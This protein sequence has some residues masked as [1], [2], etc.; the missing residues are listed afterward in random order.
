MAT[1]FTPLRY[2]G[3]KTVYADLLLEFIRLNGLKDVVLVE[4]YAGGAGASIKLLLQ[5]KVQ[6]LILNDLDPAIY[7]FW[8]SVVNAPEEM[9]AMIRHCRV[10]ISEWKR[11]REINRRKDKRDL[12]G[13]GFST[14]YLN[15][16]NRSGILTANP[17]G[18]MS[19]RGDYKIDARFNKQGLMRKIEAIADRANEIEVYNGTCEK[20]ISVLNKRSDREKLLVY[21]DPPYYQKGPLLYLNHYTQNDHAKLARRILRCKF[22]WILSYDR[23]AAIEQLYAGVLQYES[24]LRYTI[25]GNEKAKELVVTDLI[26]PSELK[27]IRRRK[28]DG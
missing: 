18:G 16:C 10:S 6:K 15:R 12:L 26:A 13:L 19:Q 20:L 17:I 9:L 8:W 22:R 23:H 24:E 1:T 2:P 21:F 3:G 7:A 5:N 28:K 27:K 25:V 4:P 14:L 11:Q